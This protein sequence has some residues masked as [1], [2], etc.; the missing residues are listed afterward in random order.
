MLEDD[1]LHSCTDAVGLEDMDT[2]AKHTESAHNFRAYLRAAVR[3][4]A[5]QHVV[6]VAPPPRPNQKGKGTRAAFVY[7]GFGC[8]P[9]LVFPGAV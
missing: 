1:V 4:Y 7:P 3:T 9:L 8:L 6:A 2:A 5:T